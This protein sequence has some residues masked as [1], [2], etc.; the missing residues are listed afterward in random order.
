MKTM[1]GMNGSKLDAVIRGEAAVREAKAALRATKAKQ[2]QVARRI[3]AEIHSLLGAA[4]AA[5]LEIATD[6]NAAVRA[7]V[8]QVLAR[9]YDTRT[10]TRGLLETNGWL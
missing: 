10:S 8:R 4:I 2:R 9:T 7:Y 6:E 1:N 5:D 3:A